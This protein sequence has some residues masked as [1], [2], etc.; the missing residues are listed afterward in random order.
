M[1]LVHKTAPRGHRRSADGLAQQGQSFSSKGGSLHQSLRPNARIPAQSCAEGEDMSMQ[2]EM[3]KRLHHPIAEAGYCAPYLHLLED[4]IA[5]KTGRRSAYTE[6]KLKQ[7]S[8]HIAEGCGQGRGD[9]Y[10]PWIR[11][12]RNFSSP[13]SYQE[14]ESVALHERNHHFL[15]RLEFHTALQVAYLGPEELRECLPLWPTEHPHPDCFLSEDDRLTDYPL[16]PGL[17]DIAQRVGIDHGCYVGTT[18]PYVASLD[19]VF[20]F[21]NEKQQ[22]R[23]LGISCKPREILNTSNRAQERV[24]LDA[25]YCKEVGALHHVEDGSGIDQQLVRNLEWLRP[26]TSELRQWKDTTDLADFSALFEAYAEDRSIEHATASAAHR[27]NLT[28]HKAQLFFRLGCWLRLID[29][30]LR[31]PVLMTRQIIRG[32]SDVVDHLRENYL[33]EQACKS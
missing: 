10:K 5:H 12:R 3:G 24:S 32:S 30:N 6:K 9:A 13:V 16:V 22:F 21:K 20:R 31:R 25:H 19:L 2:S 28:L 17:L 23:L 1:N 29:I 15:S 7:I 4:D 8:R 11:I 26:I 14:F 18:T 33:R 27:M